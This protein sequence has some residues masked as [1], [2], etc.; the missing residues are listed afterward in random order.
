MQVI[1]THA[2]TQ[3]DLLRCVSPFVAHCVVR[4]DAARRR[5]LGVKPTCPGHGAIGAID[6]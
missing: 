6:P 2:T 3:V 5:E 1:E 4:C